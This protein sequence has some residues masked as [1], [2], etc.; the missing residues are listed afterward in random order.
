M[1][2][3]EIKTFTPG[4]EVTKYYDLDGIRYTTTY[5]VVKVSDKSVWLKELGFHINDYGGGQGGA[6]S[7]TD[8]PIVR[9]TKRI[10][11]HYGYEY[12]SRPYYLDRIT[13]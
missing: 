10:D 11:T 5:L 8:E 1:N 6:S 9:Y 3:K 2:T 4:T 7:K 12:V 13:A